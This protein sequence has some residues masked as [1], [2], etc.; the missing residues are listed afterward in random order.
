MVSTVTGTVVD[1]GTR[2]IPMKN[3]TQGQNMQ[4]KMML[5]LQHRVLVG[6]DNGSKSV[7]YFNIPTRKIL[8]LRNYKFLT[9]TNP[10]P[11][12]EVA[13]DPP[14]DKGEANLPKDKGEDA[15]LSEGEEG[16]SDTWR[17]TQNGA[18]NLSNQSQK[19][20]AKK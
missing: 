1:L 15:P 2:S 16:E 10:S 17:D 14:S 12:E 20:N 18:K 8:T 5:K 7:K 3:P 11:P 9:L 4:Q 6:Y 13:V 19:G